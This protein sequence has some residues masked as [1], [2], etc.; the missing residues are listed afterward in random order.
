MSTL[1]AGAGPALAPRVDGVDAEVAPPA[2][3]P[4]GAAGAVAAA[5]V[6]AAPDGAPA[7]AEAAGLAAEESPA[8]AACAISDTASGKTKKTKAKRSGSRPF[9]AESPFFF[10]R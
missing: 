6:A 2:P 1:T 5:G 10:R 8:G 7:G 3:E 9:M 4:A